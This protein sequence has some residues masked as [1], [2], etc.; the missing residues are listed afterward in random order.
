M[1]LGKGAKI[2]LA[3]DY[4]RKVNSIIINAAQ[5]TNIRD[6]IIAKLMLIFLCLGSKYQKTRANMRKIP[7][8]PYKKEKDFFVKKPINK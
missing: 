6:S 3:L 5:I 8:I 4:L 1:C 7:G 2:G